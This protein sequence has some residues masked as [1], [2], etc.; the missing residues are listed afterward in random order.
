MGFLGTRRW[1]T[2]LGQTWK[3]RRLPIMS[4]L[5]Q[6]TGICVLSEHF[7]FAPIGDERGDLH[8]ISAPAKLEWAG[9]T[10]HD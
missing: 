6:T 1:M 3:W 9:V 10:W 8:P 4:V 5:P 7:R 2:A